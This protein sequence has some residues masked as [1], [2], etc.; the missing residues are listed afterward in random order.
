M[1]IE[2]LD[3]LYFDWLYSQVANPRIPDPSRTYWKLLRTFFTKKAVWLIANDVNRLED[4]K[5][6][7]FK[8]LTEKKLDRPNR[9]W[10]ELEC[11]FLELM[12]GL[13]ERL[14]FEAEGEPH[15]WFWKM[16][17]NLGLDRFSDDREFPKEK[18]EDTVDVVI[19]RNYKKNGRG[20]FF[21]LNHTQKDQRKVELWYQ[22]AEYLLEQ[23]E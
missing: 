19:F 22:V 21:P 20:G 13:A 9:E 4:G 1:S 5:E 12:V 7:R 14:S 2:P 8:F 23:S 16:V 11:S 15:Y 18:I 6:L 10:M 17:E 3:E